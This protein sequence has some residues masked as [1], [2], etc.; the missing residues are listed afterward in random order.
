MEAKR[1][2]HFQTRFKKITFERW[3]MLFKNALVSRCAMAGQGEH[4]LPL[5][6]IMDYG[7]IRLLKINLIYSELSS[8][9]KF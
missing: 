4:P 2:T 9:I 8:V 1:K 5:S 3:F 7:I 6:T